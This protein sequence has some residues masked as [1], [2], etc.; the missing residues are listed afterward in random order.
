MFQWLVA[1]FLIVGHDFIVGLLKKALAVMVMMYR[2]KILF[3]LFLY[4][5][6]LNN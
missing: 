2:C 5:N 6:K 3:V 1:L 4:T